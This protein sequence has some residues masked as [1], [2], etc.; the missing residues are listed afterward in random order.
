MDKTLAEIA[1][2]VGGE[3]VGDENIIITGIN[4]LQEAK[5]GDLTFVADSK[6]IS[7]AKTTEAT[8]LIV[9]RDVQ[10]PGKACILTD[11]P[12]FS[13]SKIISFIYEQDQCR[14]GGIHPS[15]VIDK[16]A[17]IGKNV[18]IGPCVVVEGQVILGDNTVIHSGCHIGYKTK[19]GQNCQIYPNVTIREKVEIGQKVII[20]SGAVV[21]A[22][23][24]GFTEVDGVHE[25]IP[26]IGTVC[27]E[28]DVE[29]GANVTIDRARFDKTIIG[30]GTKIDNLVQIAHNVVIG[31]NC[32]VVSQTG[33]SGS[34]HIGNRAILAGQVGVVG[35]LT[36]GEGAVVT[37]RAVVRKSIPSFTKVSGDPARPHIEELR[38]QI[39][40]K[41]LPEYIKKIDDLEKKIKILEKRIEGKG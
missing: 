3:V 2:I 17:V 35:H 1:K 38:G 37:G 28:D 41:K 34:V 4:G 15:A 20:H 11:N 8:A 13:F 26:Q 27:I 25:K 22:D 5:K 14:I 21:G 30:R 24:F 19:I 10:I 39:H 36:I 12:S 31:E 18:A 16:E 7:L 23:G 33:I 29:I 9:S 6:F 40:I 32:I